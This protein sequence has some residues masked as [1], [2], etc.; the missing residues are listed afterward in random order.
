MKI[1]GLIGTFGS[2]LCAVPGDGAMD[3]DDVDEEEEVFGCLTGSGCLC[4]GAKLSLDCSIVCLNMFAGNLPP[5][6]GCQ[7]H[8]KSLIQMDEKRLDFIFFLKKFGS[9]T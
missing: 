9:G 6:G 1:L 7:V 8:I 5:V 3:G 4:C 2:A